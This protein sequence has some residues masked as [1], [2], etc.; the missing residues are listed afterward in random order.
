MRSSYLGEAVVTGV[1]QHEAQWDVPS[2]DPAMGGHGSFGC[3]LALAQPDKKVIVFD[4]E[5]DL[6]MNLGIL[7]TIAEQ[8]PKNF[9][10]FLLD[11]ECYATTGR[12]ARAQCQERSLRCS[13]TRRWI[14]THLRLRSLED[15]ASGIQAILDQ[16]GPVFVA[17]KVVPEIENEPIGRRRRWQTHSREQ[18]V[19]D[20][21]VEL[22]L[23][24]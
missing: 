4:S 19:Q 16:P 8:A 10:H 13:G 15:F 3:G 6:L 18:V 21:Q 1:A 20:L 22:G 9:H 23:T 24:E 2:G 11:N 12:T 17:M 7:P 14:S 5:G